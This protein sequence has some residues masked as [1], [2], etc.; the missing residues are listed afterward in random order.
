MTAADRM[1]FLEVADRL[2]RGL[3]RDALWAGRACNWLGW[4]M[5]PIGGA[6][7]PAYRAFG[8]DLYSG[9]TGIALFLARLYAFQKDSLI[10]QTILGALEQSS[11]RAPILTEEVRV[12]FYAGLTGIAY[13]WIQIGQVLGQERWIQAGIRALSE[14]K[15]SPPHARALDVISGSAGAIPALI[16]VG[17]RFQRPDLIELAV[18]HGE[19]LLT[20]AIRSDQG[21]SWD[22]MHVPN[23][24]PLTGYSHGTAGIV[25]AL[26]EVHRISG[27]GRL[28]EAA[29]Q[30]LRYERGLFNAEQ[31][32]W[33]DLRVFDPN[34]P[35]ANP[36]YALAWCHGA[37]GIGLA[38]LRTAQLLPDDPECPREIEIAAETT[39]RSL[40]HPVIPGQG[41]FSLCHGAGGNADFLLFADDLLTRPAWRL[42]AEQVG[43]QGIEQFHRTGLPW[44]CGLMQAGVTPNLMLGLAGIGYFYLRLYDSKAV[45][46]PLIC[47]PA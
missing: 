11:E 47:V 34:A 22:T 21:W 17:R 24:K 43:R 35:P 4:A 16:D 41:N 3:C 8:P 26:L 39:L 1:P 37:P 2:G 13:A 32:N 28:V 44:P 42:R 36:G 23:Q 5:E 45:P 15:A 31:A 14:L 7:V 9:T 12:G 46:S 25:C 10:R 33:P 38:R 27:D 18:K 20:T 40:Q 19:H 6:W 30:G 29:R